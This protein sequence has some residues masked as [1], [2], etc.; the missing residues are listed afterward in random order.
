M[1]S[2]VAPPQ[3]SRS[4][5]L[6]R[7]V[8]NFLF[9]HELD[10]ASPVTKITE[11]E[12]CQEPPK[13]HLGWVFATFWATI[14]L[15]RWPNLVSQEPSYWYCFAGTSRRPCPTLPS[16]TGSPTWRWS[17][18]LRARNLKSKHSWVFRSRLFLRNFSLDGNGLLLI[19]TT[20]SHRMGSS[21][22]IVVYVYTTISVGSSHQCHIG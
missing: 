5:F 6:C 9:C 12:N 22:E 14:F 1:F 16:P 21:T 15:K 17:T 7:S 4:T 8:R 11:Q 18:R 19:A 13:Q 2:S 10:W 20:L 3:N